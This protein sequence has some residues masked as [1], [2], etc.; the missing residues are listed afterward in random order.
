MFDLVLSIVAM[1]GY[2][3]RQ[4]YSHL[5]KHADNR[6]RCVGNEPHHTLLLEKLIDGKDQNKY[7]ANPLADRREQKK[8]VLP[9][10]SLRNLGDDCLDLPSKG[11]V[12]FALQCSPNVCI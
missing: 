7:G 12:R 11:Q 3:D 5:N 4:K 8:S 2:P 1:D 9:T 6:N 10:E